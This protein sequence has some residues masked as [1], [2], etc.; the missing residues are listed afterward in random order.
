MFK[1]HQTEDFELQNV[2]VFTLQVPSVENFDVYKT[3]EIWWIFL[4]KLNN[5]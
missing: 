4:F 5:E 1:E 3:C 2:H